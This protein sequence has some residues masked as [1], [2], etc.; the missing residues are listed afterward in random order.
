MPPARR[1]ARR[2]RVGSFFF[3]LGF[4]VLLAATFGAGVFVGRTWPAFPSVLARAPEGAPRREGRAER[5]SAA[6]APVLTFYH[7]LTAP[8]TAP[9]VTPP[10]PAKTVPP[11]PAVPPR[12]ALAP[13]VPARED[14]AP[15]IAPALEPAAGAPPPASVVPGA[16]SEA[17]A[18][19]GTPG[20]PAARTV[21]A[22]PPSGSRFTIQV[23][24]FKDRPPAEALRATLALYG[25]DVYIAES[26]GDGARFRV[27][28]GSYATRDEARAAAGRIAAERHVTTYVTPR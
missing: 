15:A 13:A 2:S 24:A 7:E 3:M 16:V 9:P 1:Q 19:L 11:A 25:H 20:A 8:L 26:D 6:S 10:K 14:G 12:P 21:S 28:V 5:K 18:P 23:G 22:G 27:R 17:S 4:M